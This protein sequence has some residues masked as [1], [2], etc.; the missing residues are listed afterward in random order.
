L[1]DATLG[2]T[3]DDS[4]IAMSEDELFDLVKVGWSA[5]R[6]RQFKHIKEGYLKAGKGEKEAAKLAGMTVNK[7]RREA[8]EVKKGTEVFEGVPEPNSDVNMSL[9]PSRKPSKETNLMK[10]MAKAGLI[11][12]PKGVKPAMKPP[13]MAM[14]KVPK[15]ITKA[16]PP[17]SHPGNA[18][19]EQKQSSENTAHAIGAAPAKPKFDPRSIGIGPSGKKL[20]PSLKGMSKSEAIE[21]VF[22]EMDT[23][24]KSSAPEA[25]AQ[26][27]QLGETVIQIENDPSWK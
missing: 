17:P 25:Q 19:I 3:G 27:Q 9:N 4:D 22:K 21:A 16:V 18:Q 2:S 26:L 13:K 15:P 12:A 24:R 8:G 6:D 5:K 20:M 14:P 11:A 7:E 23:L 1:T 10:P